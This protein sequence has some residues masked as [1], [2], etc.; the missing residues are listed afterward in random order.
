MKTQILPNWFKKLG[1]VI[2]F[3]ATIMNGGINFL[4]SSKLYRI[5]GIDVNS[6]GKSIE[7]DSGFTGLLS[8]FTGGAFPHYIDILAILGMLVYIIA[9]EKVE[10][11]Y[12]NKLR[13]ESF[14]LTTIIG[15][16]A[17]IIIYTTARDLMLTLDY[18]IFPFIWTYLIL[19][20]IKR[21]FYI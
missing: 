5:P 4:N 14:Q 6:V 10:D 11:D 19:F 18:Y 12:I 3:F 2:F 17:A 9:R 13:L 21:R 1:L 15:L 8:A 20:V 16:I 7:Y